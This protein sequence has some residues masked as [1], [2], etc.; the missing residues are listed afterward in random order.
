M[1]TVKFVKVRII[2]QQQEITIEFFHKIFSNIFCTLHFPIWESKWYFIKL[3]KNKRYINIYK[4]TNIQIY[5]STNIQIYKY[6]SKQIYKYT[7]IQIYNY[8]NL[9]I[10]KYTNMQIYKYTNIQIYKYTNIQIYKQIRVSSKKKP[11]SFNKICRN[12][13]VKSLLI[14]NTCRFFT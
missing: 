10:Y 8:T 7:T 12:N 2:P 6:T 14:N 4:Y 1:T 3:F 13:S 11:W 9:Q 5:K